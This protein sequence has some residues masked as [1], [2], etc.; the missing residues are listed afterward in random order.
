MKQTWQVWKNDDK[1]VSLEI[2]LLKA[3][4]DNKPPDAPSGSLPSSGV[5]PSFS[6]KDATSRFDAPSGGMVAPTPPWVDDATTPHF[7]TAPD[8]T[9]LFCNIHDKVKV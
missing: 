4:K 6:V 5:V 8:S 9:K 1:F 3:I 7:N 2:P